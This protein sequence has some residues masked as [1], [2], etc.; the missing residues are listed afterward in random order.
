MTAPRWPLASTVSVFAANRAAQ[1]PQ[2]AA[3]IFVVAGND[4]SGQ[5]KLP[6]LHAPLRAPSSRQSAQRPLTPV[7]RAWQAC[8]HSAACGLHASLAVAHSSTQTG[9]FT[10]FTPMLPEHSVAQSIGLLGKAAAGQQALPPPHIPALAFSMRHVAQSGCI[11]LTR[12]WHTASHSRT[13]AAHAASVSLQ[14]ATQR[15]SLGPKSLVE[16]ESLQ[17]V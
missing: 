16:S 12:T 9:W 13:S 6:T 4:G 3:H 8:I 17:A 2:T 11:S 15:A 7:T 1:A 5:H 10:G 14:S